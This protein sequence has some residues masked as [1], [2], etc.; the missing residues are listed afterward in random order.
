MEREE[1]NARNV[2]LR[3]VTWSTVMSYQLKRGTFTYNF[4]WR[5]NKEKEK[6]KMA[7]RMVN[8]GCKNSK[9]SLCSMLHKNS[10]LH[11]ACLAAKFEFLVL[12][13]HQSII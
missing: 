13:R 8:R 10:L 9:K 7:Q 5:R 1:W 2:G 4:F 12:E 11:F 3:F 6:Y